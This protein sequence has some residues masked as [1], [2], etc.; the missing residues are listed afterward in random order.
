MSSSG[1]L[2]GQNATSGPTRHIQ[3]SVAPCL[4][5]LHSLSLCLKTLDCNSNS[6]FICLLTQNEIT[7][8]YSRSGFSVLLWI[9]HQ[10][11]A[12]KEVRA[13]ARLDLGPRGT[14]P[15]RWG[16]YGRGQGALGAQRGAQGGGAGEPLHTGP[17]HEGE[18]IL[19]VDWIAG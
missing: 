17:G 10:Y 4:M 14:A 13:A 1:G 2:S 6:L 3:R 15:V 19:S 9:Q 11:L 18:A 16:Q 12:I 5:R 8:S 7:L